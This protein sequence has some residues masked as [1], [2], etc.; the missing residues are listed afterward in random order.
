MGQSLRPLGARSNFQRR[1]PASPLPAKY[2]PSGLNTIDQNS[3]PGSG[4]TS[5][6]ACQEEVSQRRAVP[7]L[8]T[9]SK[10]PSG[11]N[12]SVCTPS[13]KAA[14]RWTL[15]PVATFQR[16]TV[17][18]LLPAASS[19]PS[20]LKATTGTPPMWPARIRLSPAPARFQIRQERNVVAKS[21]LPSGVK[22]APRGVPGKRRTATSRLV[23]RFHKRTTPSCDDGIARS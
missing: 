21:D 6:S 14:I 22:N 15:S 12:A 5:A 20:G 16:E 9:A 1:T 4:G 2:V 19:P 17:L 18:S 8:L 10:R 3:P 11:W 7:P 23:A 13:G